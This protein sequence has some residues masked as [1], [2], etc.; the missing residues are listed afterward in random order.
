MTGHPIRSSILHE[1]IKLTCGDRDKEYGDPKQNMTCAGEL[2][3]TI[4]RYMARDITPAELEALDMVLTK[5]SRVI[6]GPEVKRDTFVDMATYA[7]IAGEM[8]IRTVLETPEPKPTASEEAPTEERLSEQELNAR[9]FWLACGDPKRAYAGGS[10]KSPQK[11]E[12]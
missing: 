5:M 8:A 1:G 2:K 3:A 4:R 9:A 7:A 6:T 12:L 11:V 10:S